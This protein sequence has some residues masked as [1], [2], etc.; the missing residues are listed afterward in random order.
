MMSADCYDVAERSPTPSCD[1]RTK[2]YDVEEPINQ[3]VE[4]PR[5]SLL[6]LPHAVE[7]DF[8]SREPVLHALEPPL[9]LKLVPNVFVERAREQEQKFGIRFLSEPTQLNLLKVR[10]F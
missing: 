6:L 3:N 4:V 7:T 5:A 2:F 10:G 1:E 9:S 8:A